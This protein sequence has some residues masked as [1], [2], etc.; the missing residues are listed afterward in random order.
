LPESFTIARLANGAG[1]HIETVR[2]YQRLRLIPKPTRP[3]RGVRRYTSDDVERLR[4]IKRA[5]TMGFTLG[6]MPALLELKEQRS[7]RA[8]RELAT[9]KLHA[10]DAQ[11]RSLRKLR[12]ELAALVSEC[13]SNV[14]D[15]K[16]PVIDRLA[17]RT[18]HKHSHR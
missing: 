6:E 14:D 5:Q 3:T 8:T 11:I 12:A 10:I 9:S 13:S 2:Y 18:S 1:V 4:F 15:S 17:Q 7:C 16:C